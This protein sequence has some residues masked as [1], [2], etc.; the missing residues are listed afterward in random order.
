MPGHRQ[1]GWIKADDAALALEHGALEVVIE[2]HPWASSPGDERAEVSAQKVLHVRA[3]IKPQKDLPR[4]GQHRHKG[5]ER[6]SRL[7]DLQVIKVTPVNL[8]LLGRQTAQTQIRLGLGARAVSCDQVAEVIRSPAVAPRLDHVVEATGAQSRK[9]LQGLQDKRQIGINPRWPQARSQPGQPGLAKHARHAVAMHVKVA[10]DGANRPS[11]RMIAAQNLRF[12]FRGQCHVI[13]CQVG[14]AESDD[15]GSPGVPSLAARH[16]IARSTR[17]PA[18][19]RSSSVREPVEQSGGSVGNPDESL[20]AFGRG[21]GVAARHGRGDHA[22]YAGNALQPRAGRA[23]GPPLRKPGCNSGC[24]DRSGCRSTP[25][26]GSARTG[27]VFQE[28]PLAGTA[29]GVGA[30][31]A[32]VVTYFV[33]NVAPGS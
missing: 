1:Q 21:S 6:A 15:A 17:A 27:T 13:S 9:P 32:R 33:C 20:S 11:L 30:R 29:N 22:D 10:G 28:R 26:C 12:S 23:G 2:R 4:P 19:P 24:R 31:N 8:H 7:T 14:F 5:H 16:D 25:Q 3:Q 18:G